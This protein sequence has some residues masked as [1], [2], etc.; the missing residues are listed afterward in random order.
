MMLRVYKTKLFKYLMHFLHVGDAEINNAFLSFQASTPYSIDS[1][2]L[3]MDCII[4]GSASP[5]M[6]I[7][8]VTNKV[9]LLICVGLQNPLEVNRSL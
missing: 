2:S 9:S 4:S 5:N 3:G 8:T 1:D 6:A 7:N